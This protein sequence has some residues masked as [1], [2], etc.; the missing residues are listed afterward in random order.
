MLTGAAASIPLT[1]IAFEVTAVL[2]AT[3]VCGVKVKTS[4]VV[5]P[6]GAEPSRKRVGVLR[7]RVDKDEAPDAGE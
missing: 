6:V 3:P 7:H 2:A 4:G 1:V 5:S